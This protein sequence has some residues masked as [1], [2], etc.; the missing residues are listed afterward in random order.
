MLMWFCVAW[1]SAD[2]MFIGGSIQWILRGN[3]HKYISRW[4]LSG[5]RA[6]VKVI[7][8]DITPKLYIYCSGKAQAHSDSGKE[9]EWSVS[10]EK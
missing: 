3:W 8:V 9:I 10:C 7:S 1:F 4:F 2:C 5:A 6:S